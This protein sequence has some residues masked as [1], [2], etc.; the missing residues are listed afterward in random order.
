MSLG[1]DVPHAEPVGVCK[2]RKIEASS[3]SPSADSL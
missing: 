1:I 3:S 2:K